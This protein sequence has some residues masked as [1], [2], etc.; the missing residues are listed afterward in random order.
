MVEALA[1]STTSSLK[2]LDQE[3]HLHWAWNVAVRHIIILKSKSQGA[4]EDTTGG[5][6]C[7]IMLGDRLL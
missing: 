4:K 3:E 5:A 7:V 2:K 1:R 6:N